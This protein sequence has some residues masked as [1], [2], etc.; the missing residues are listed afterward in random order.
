MLTS[1]KDPDYHGWDTDVISHAQF[2]KATPGRAEWEMT[3]RPEMCNKGG[4]LHGGC[5]T[6]I[7]DN[8]SSSTFLTVAK[9]GF[10]DQGTVSRT[11]LMTFLRS[12]KLAPKHGYTNLYRPVPVGTKVRIV[13][14]V[15]LLYCLIVILS[16]QPFLVG[17]V[18]GLTCATYLAVIQT[19]ILTKNQA[20][21]GGKRLAHCKGQIETL[22]GKVAVTCIHD[23]AVVPRR[24]KL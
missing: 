19:T 23:K 15:R 4:N 13:C 18:F 5:A 3:V 9:E 21:A 8:L 7:L 1:W 17:S 11:I 20:V 2:I 16:E 6:T 10:M 22:D 14:E 24:T 12:V